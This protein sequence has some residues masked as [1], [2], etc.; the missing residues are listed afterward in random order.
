MGES[1]PTIEA[2]KELVSTFP[3]PSISLH[4]EAQRNMESK[5]TPLDYI[6]SGFFTA[7]GAVKDTGI[8]VKDK[9]GETVVGQKI[10]GAASTAGHFV[11][12]KTKMVGAAI[13]NQGNRIA[14]MNCGYC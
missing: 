10:A 14:V 13:K 7:I 11:V 2:G 5:K 9:I 4:V 12:D 1:A 6:S 3:E 8:K